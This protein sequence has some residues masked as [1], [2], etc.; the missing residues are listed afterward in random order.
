MSYSSKLTPDNVLASM[1]L[2]LCCKKGDS[3]VLLKSDSLMLPGC[4]GDSAEGGCV[5]RRKGEEGKKL[6]KKT[7]R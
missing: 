1:V 2:T 6:R 4:T 3:L 7:R 5:D